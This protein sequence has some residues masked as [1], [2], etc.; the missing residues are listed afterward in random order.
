M[1]IPNKQESDLVS[2]IQKILHMNK[3]GDKRKDR[4]SGRSH[5]SH[6][7]DGTQEVCGSSRKSKSSPMKVSKSTHEALTEIFKLIG[8]KKD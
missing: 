5:Q 1:L 8:T 2:Y 3:N 6:D 7:Q 4:R